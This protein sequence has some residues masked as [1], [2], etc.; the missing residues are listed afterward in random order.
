MMTRQAWSKRWNS[1]GGREGLSKDNQKHANDLINED[2]EDLFQGIQEE[3]NHFKILRFNFIATTSFGWY[4]AGRNLKNE[5]NF[6]LFNFDEISNFFGIITIRCFWAELRYGF[7]FWVIISQKS[8][9]W[10]YFG[11]LRCLMCSNHLK[12]N[13]NRFYSQFY[14]R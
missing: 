8:N 3:P 1:D 11:I 7:G 10:Q 14:T 13:Q 12:V 5:G 4:D 2:E 6:D 9:F